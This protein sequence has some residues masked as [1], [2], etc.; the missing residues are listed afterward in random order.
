MAFCL[1]AQAGLLAH[2]YSLLATAWGPLAAGW[3]MAAVTACAV[4]GRTLVARCMPAGTDRRLVASASIAVQVA[5]SLLLW[6]TQGQ[7]GALLLL[8]V[9]LFGAGIGNATSLPPLVAQVEFVKEDVARVVAL[10]VALSQALMSLAPVA[11]GVLL[12]AGGATHADFA[13]Q[14]FFGTA[15]LVQ[16]AAIACMLAGRAR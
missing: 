16:L 13:T 11:F 1:F 10:I 8:G 5:G 12:A 14:W 6:A 2:L 15:A 7:Q 9:L 3:A 4:G